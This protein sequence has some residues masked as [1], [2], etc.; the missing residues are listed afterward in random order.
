MII[1]EQTVGDAD[2]LYE[3]YSDPE[4]KRFTEDLYEDRDREIQYLK[5]Y[6]N[7]QY[8]FCEYG[9]W[10]L[11]DKGTGTLIGRAGISN[12]ADYDEAE[13]GYVIRKEYRKKG[14]ATEACRAILQCADAELGLQKINAFTLKENTA[15][16]ALLH[17]LGF[18][19][20]GTGIIDGKEHEMY[21]IGF[22]LG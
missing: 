12:R 13:L 9:V 7:N 11:V 16:I 1:R 21:T 6:I 20:C 2:A 14:Y 8:R 22:D 5:D 10:A 18:S 17:K 19:N 4:V 15:G 3:I